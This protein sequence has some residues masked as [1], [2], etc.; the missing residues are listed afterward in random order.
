MRMGV[1][2]GENRRVK[3]YSDNKEREKN[4]TQFKKQ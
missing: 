4:K 2:E 3:A 1:G